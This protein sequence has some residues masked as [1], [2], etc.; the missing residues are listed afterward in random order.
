MASKAAQAKN[1]KA[2]SK[3]TARVQKRLGALRTPKGRASAK[4]KLQLLRAQRKARAPCLV[5]LANLAGKKRGPAALLNALKHH[6]DLLPHWNGWAYHLTSRLQWEE[7][8]VIKDHENNPMPDDVEG[9]CELRAAHSKAGMEKD[10]ECGLTYFV[11]VRAGY[12]YEKFWEVFAHECTHIIDQELNHILHKHDSP[13]EADYR[14]TCK[15]LK[16]G[17]CAQFRLL[18]WQI[19]GQNP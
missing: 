16:G 13:G 1:K 7:V 5:S 14:Q 19:W 12:R 2:V 8:D 11:Q 6:K 17:H 9:L 18:N 15:C 4:R 3:A 10:A